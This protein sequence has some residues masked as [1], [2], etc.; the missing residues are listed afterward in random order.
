LEYFEDFNVGGVSSAPELYTVDPDGFEYGL[1]EE[2][3]VCSGK[4]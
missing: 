4:F 2:K 1:V 3:F